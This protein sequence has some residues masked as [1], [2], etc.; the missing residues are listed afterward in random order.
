MFQLADFYLLQKKSDP[1]EAIAGGKENSV[2]DTR[3]SIVFLSVNLSK[4]RIL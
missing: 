1:Y 3:K 4:F 2:E